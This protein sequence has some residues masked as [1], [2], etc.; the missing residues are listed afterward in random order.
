NPALGVKSVQELIELAKREPGK[1][2]YASSGPGT[3]QHMAAALFDALA[4]TKM[5]HVPFKGASQMLPELLA[6]RIQV[7]F[8]PANTVL[9]HVR[10]GDLIALAVAGDKRWEPMPELPTVAEQGVKGY[11]VDLWYALL[12]PANTPSGI[13]TALNRD[14]NA[15]VDD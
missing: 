1:L 9:P 6:N 14:L 13:L 12:A 7:L 8:G 15:Y 11:K 2:N 3:V 10:S 5:E 4:G